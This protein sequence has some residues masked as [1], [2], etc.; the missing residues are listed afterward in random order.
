MNDALE[1]VILVDRE[2]RPIGTAPKL[3]AHVEG[4]LHRAFSVLIDDGGGNLLLQRRAAGKYHSGG[5]W[6]NACCG[7]PRPGEDTQLAA[8][9]RLAE[10]MG[11]SCPIVPMQTVVYRAD[12][13]G[14][15]IEHEYVHLFAGRW[16]GAVVPDPDEAEAHAWRDFN[17]V[18][19]DAAARPYRYTAWFRLYLRDLRLA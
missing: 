13:G 8:Q 11:F 12:V 10:E 6:T 19:A 4:R 16:H 7:H 1:R 5:L 2:D 9:R 18:T 3:G 17:S 15:L 14:G